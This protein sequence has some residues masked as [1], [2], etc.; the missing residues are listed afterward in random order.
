MQKLKKLSITII[1]GL[2]L[3]LGL[4]MIVL[5]GPAILI[6]PL[7]LTI[8]A[9][10]YQWAKHYLKISQR[11]LSQAGRKM[12]AFIRKLKRKH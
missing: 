1:G 12:A 9:L 5:P 4:I 6:I 3:L 11:M 10:E 2:L 7:A 8:L